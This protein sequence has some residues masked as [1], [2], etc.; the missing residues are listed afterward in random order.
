MQSDGHD[1]TNTPGAPGSESRASVPDG[2]ARALSELSG[3]QL[4]AHERSQLDEAVL[5]AVR[6]E[7]AA[8]RRRRMTH[9]W[10]RR[11]GAVAAIAGLALVVVVA[12]PG[13]STP[14]GQRLARDP[15][16]LNADGVVDIL[17]V[18]ALAKAVDRSYPPAA[19]CDVNADG[20]IDRLDVDALAGRV[21]R[22]DNAGS[23]RGGGRLGDAL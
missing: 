20:T 11:A 18:Y 5:S 9:A 22:L 13:G 21:V 7:F 15:A 14:P 1:N 2:L 19:V 12:W 16:D 6:D 8:R 23:P 17:D 4:G 3:P 10:G